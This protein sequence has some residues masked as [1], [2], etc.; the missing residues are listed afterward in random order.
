MQ[1]GLI[2]TCP[3]HDDATSYLTYFSKNI[4]SQAVLNRLKNKQI[5]DQNL[6]FNDFSQIIEKL[7]YKFL[8]LNAHG[9]SEAIFGYK[10]NII[11]QLGKNEALLKDRIIYAR[12][13]NAGGKL[14]SECMKNTRKG[15]FIGYQLPFIFYMDTKWTA[16]PSNDNAAKL[17]LEPSNLIPISII[18]GH[19]GIEAHD[20]AKRQILKTMNKLMAGK[21]EQE[22]PFYLEALWNN[23]IG[24]VIHGD[25]TARL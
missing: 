13:C 14:G 3:E 11:I 5:S 2:I 25:E 16:K 18:K 19:S 8:V 22:T 12:S 9:S 17:F 21:Q 7:D 23:Y 10:D 1:K 15:C 4:I 24:Q 20:H 6:N